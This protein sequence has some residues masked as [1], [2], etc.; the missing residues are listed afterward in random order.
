MANRYRIV[1]MH[2]CAGEAQIMMA[3]KAA[4]AATAP[5]PSHHRLGVFAN[6]RHHRL[7]AHFGVGICASQRANRAP[8]HPV[9]GALA[10]RSR[11]R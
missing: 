10:D 9:S 8:S 11:I 3:I 2:V 7:G 5:S 1:R 6:R 4:I